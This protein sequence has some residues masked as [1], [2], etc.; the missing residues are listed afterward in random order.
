[1]H[2]SEYPDLDRFCPRNA[3]CL[4]EWCS[5]STAWSASCLVSTAGAGKAAVKPELLDAAANHPFEAV[6]RLIGPHSQESWAG[7]ATERH[8]DQVAA[9]KQRCADWYQTNSHSLVLKLQPEFSICLGH[10]A[11]SCASCTQRSSDGSIGSEQSGFGFWSSSQGLAG[12]CYLRSHTAGY[13]CSKISH[14]HHQWAT[15]G[16]WPK[17]FA[18]LDLAADRLG[19]LWCTF[20]SCC[21]LQGALAFHLKVNWFDVAIADVQKHVHPTS[22]MK[23]TQHHLASTRR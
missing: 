11:F 10:Y 2:W 21:S 18:E 6:P 4:V 1:M 22:A 8:L 19:P 5:P 7:Q 15:A 3:S 13:Y 12:S 9:Q 16:N 14:I 23:A 17:L 20:V